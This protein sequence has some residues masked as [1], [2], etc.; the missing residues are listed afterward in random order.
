M[1]KKNIKIKNNSEKDK[2]IKKKTRKR[3]ILDGILVILALAGIAGASL[4]LI[5]ALYIIIS[6]PDFDQEL[7][8]SQEATVM[9]DINNE[10]IARIGSENR[11]LI[12]Y[13]ELPQVLIDALIATEDSR[14]FQHNGLD[15]ARFLVASVKQAL[16]DSKAGGASTLSMQVIKN[17][18]TGKQA[19][20]GSF[21]MTL[22]SYC[23]LP[24]SMV[25][26]GQVFTVQ[27]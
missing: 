19:E 23:K 26:G 4:V 5:F 25:Y 24:V 1:K 27:Q 3:K 14:F 18:Y 8:Y 12:T 9:Y 11:D 6:S 21:V 16:G 10:E 13:E 22:A 15:G 7:L 20:N 2:K 17:T